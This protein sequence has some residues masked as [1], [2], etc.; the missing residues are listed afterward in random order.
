[1]MTHNKEVEHVEVVPETHGGQNESP[2]RGSEQSEPVT[3]RQKSTIGMPYI[4]VALMFFGV[5]R[6]FVILFLSILPKF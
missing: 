2:F 5:E 4:F 3:T 1:M 6:N